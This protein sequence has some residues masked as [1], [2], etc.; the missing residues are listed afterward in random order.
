MYKMKKR[1]FAIILDELERTSFNKNVGLFAQLLAKRNI[2][3]DFITDKQKKNYKV[4]FK[5]PLITI[6][7]IPARNVWPQLNHKN[8][9]KYFNENFNSYFG[10]WIYRGR[11]YSQWLIEE[12]NSRNIVTIVKLDSDSNISKFGE[13]YFKFCKKFNIKPIDLYNRTRIF[14][15]LLSFIPSISGFIKYDSILFNSSIVLSETPEIFKKLKN[16]ISGINV[17]LYPNSIPVSSYIK[18]EKLIKVVKNTNKILSV[19][20]L[21]PVKQFE[22]GIKAFN[23]LSPE[24]KRKWSY[25]IIGPIDDKDYYLELDR[26]IKKL[27]LEKHIKITKGLFDNDLF[28]KYSES[29]IFLLPSKT[30]GQPNVL[31]EAMFFNNAVI[32][33]TLPGTKALIDNNENGI[34]LRS[35]T[36]ENTSSAFIRII[37][38]SKFRIKITRNSR[39]SIEKDFNLDIIGESLYQKIVNLDF[40][41]YI[42]NQKS[43]TLAMEPD[44]IENAIIKYLSF[45]TDK[46]KKVINFSEAKILDVGCREFFTYDYFTKNYNNKILGVDILEPAL[47]FAKKKNIIDVDLH[48][49]DKVLPHNKYDV[50]L[51]FHVFEHMYDLEKVL[52]NCNKLLK[53]G[54]LLFFAIP[55]PAV[56]TRRFHWVN[57]SSVKE[58]RD[59]MVKLNYKPIYYK[60]SKANVF[61]N[62]PEMIGIFQ[63]K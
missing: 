37:N 54:G 46:Y 62:E 2:S 6:K 24:I 50:I 15:K 26:L 57:I 39:R 14:I 38:D 36:P 61:R 22:I 40:I 59:I 53:P 33:T 52:N 1:K 7:R 56:D 49:I 43:D 48:E 23:L 17:F 21:T 19:G 29:K 45:F 32:A 42:N 10:I 41:S 27:K 44:V 63:K 9:K 55:M 5:S 58:M 30:E 60:F 34:L 47:N 11:P 18:K 4:K 51:A 25:E 13:F 35:C 28:K 20:R 8:F 3:V 16:E 12:A 31:T